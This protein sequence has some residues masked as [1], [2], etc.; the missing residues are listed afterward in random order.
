MYDFRHSG[1]DI[2]QDS[3]QHVRPPHSA[4]SVRA[5]P[6]FGRDSMAGLCWTRAGITDISGIAK[7]AGKTSS[8]TSEGDSNT[9]NEV[10]S[11]A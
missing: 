7:T 1:H 5:N 4:S 2:G 9:E 10:A 3:D 6:L 11:V 8:K